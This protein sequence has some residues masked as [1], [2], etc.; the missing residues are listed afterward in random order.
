MLRSSQLVQDYITNRKPRDNRVLRPAEQMCNK[1][2]NF[3]HQ[4]WVLL[5]V[6]SETLPR[7]YQIAGCLEFR[8]ATQVKNKPASF[9]S[10]S[11]P[12]NRSS[13]WEPNSWNAGIQTCNR[14]KQVNTKSTPARV[15]SKTLVLQVQRVRTLVFRS[16]TKQRLQH[17][18]LHQWSLNHRWSR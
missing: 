14:I 6:D 13:S 1:D 18:I 10:R 2:D 7:Q 5:H 12:Q 9:P 17:R 15:I 11:T 16:A 3:Q 8:S 4:G